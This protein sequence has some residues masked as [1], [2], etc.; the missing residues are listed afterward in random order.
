MTTLYEQVLAEFKAI[1]PYNDSVEVMY[2]VDHDGD[3]NEILGV[4]RTGKRR[5]VKADTR[6]IFYQVGQHL[7]RPSGER[8]DA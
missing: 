3:G 4:I 2:V 1:N 6:T 8:F 5:I 7:F